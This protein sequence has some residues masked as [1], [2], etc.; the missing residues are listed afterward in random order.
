MGLILCKIQNLEGEGIGNLLAAMP[1]S[2]NKKILWI[3]CLCLL[4]LYTLKVPL[5]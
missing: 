2:R 1:Q 3:I 4:E 5:S